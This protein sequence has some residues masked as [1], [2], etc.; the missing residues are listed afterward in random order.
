MSRKPNNNIQIS[1]QCHPNVVKEV[2]NWAKIRSFKEQK[3]IDNEELSKQNK[4]V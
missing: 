3:R 2:R 1:V 4:N